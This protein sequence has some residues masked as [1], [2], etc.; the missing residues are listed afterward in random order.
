MISALY[1]FYNENKSNAKEMPATGLPNLYPLDETVLTNVGLK[2]R[3]NNFPSQLSGGEQQRVSIARASYKK[4]KAS[5][6]RR[7]NRRFG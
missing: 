1:S 5:F 3:M 4:S 6:M 7:A 2:D